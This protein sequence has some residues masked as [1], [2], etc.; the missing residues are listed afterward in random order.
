MTWF[1]LDNMKKPIIVGVISIV[2][3][4]SVV[5][6]LSLQSTPERQLDMIIATQDCSGLIKWEIEH[7]FEKLDLSEQQVKDGIKLGV[8]CMRNQVSNYSP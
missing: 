1:F 4:L 7:S 2:I 3:I 5:G 6:V 8:Q